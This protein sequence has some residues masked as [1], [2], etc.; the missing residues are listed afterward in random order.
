MRL[1]ALSRKSGDERTSKMIDREPKGTK[2]LVSKRTAVIDGVKQ[3]VVNA[4][5]LYDALCVAK[6][7]E[8]WPEERKEAYALDG[9]R[10]ATQEPPRIIKARFDGKE[11]NAVK[12]SDLYCFLKGVDKA[13]L[14]DSLYED[15]VL[16][17]YAALEIAA[18]DESEQ[19][20]E[21]YA[22]LSLFDDRDETRTR[23]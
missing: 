8:V 10:A 17:I 19:S 18:N 6:P 7:F 16:R 9:Q 13:E 1:T 22:Y 4:R 5:D 11:Y 14:G 3:P 12:A 15:Y 2:K 21:L 20:G 23:Q